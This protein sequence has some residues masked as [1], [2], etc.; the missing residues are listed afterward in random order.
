MQS[1]NWCDVDGATF[2]FRQWWHTLLRSRHGLLYTLSCV[3]F[4]LG[5]TAW[6][7]KRPKD[8]TMRWTSPW[9]R[10]QWMPPPRISHRAPQKRTPWCPA[11]PWRA[12]KRKGRRRCL[13]TS[14]KNR[15]VWKD[16]LSKSFLRLGFGPPGLRV[17]YVVG[18]PK[19]LFWQL[20]WMKIHTWGIEWACI[21][22]GFF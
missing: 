10:N 22:Y 1:L 3:C 12:R 9:S 19:G 4:L 21:H 7:R 14:H 16:T 8:R 15:Q 17:S 6:E 13:W 11:S 5:W 20:S 18:S 2:C